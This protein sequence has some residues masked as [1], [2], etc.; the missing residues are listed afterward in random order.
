MTQ[1]ARPVKPGIDLTIAYPHTGPNEGY[2]VLH[3][4]GCKH[5]TQ[6]KH[7]GLYEEPR[8]LGVVDIQVA[9]GADDYFEVAPCAKG[10]A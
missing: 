10:K 6:G 5:L 1:L 3:A 9:F 8:H 4:T 7:H 2:A